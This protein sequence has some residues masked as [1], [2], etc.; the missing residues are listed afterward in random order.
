MKEHPHDALI[1]KLEECRDE[2]RELGENYKIDENEYAEA[3]DSIE[4]AV[5]TV[6]AIDL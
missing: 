2:L 4:S 3:A 6:R 1:H 5:D